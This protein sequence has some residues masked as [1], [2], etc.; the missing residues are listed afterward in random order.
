MHTTP[1]FPRLLATAVL[2][3]LTL[4]TAHA[5]D[6]QTRP[7]SGSFELIESNGG[8]DVYLSQGPTAAIVAEAAAGALPHLLTEVRNGTLVVQWEKGF[9]PWKLAQRH[10]QARVYITMPRLSGLTLSGGADGHGQTSFTADDFRIQ[11]SGGSD[12]TL[13]LQ[14]KNL[15]ADAS[16]GSDL[17]LSGRAERQEIG[18]SGGSDYH[19][20]GLQSTTAR[21]SASGGSDADAWVEGELEASA[22]GGSDLRY[23]GAGRAT[24]AHAGGASSVRHVN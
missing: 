5:Q 14:V 6:K 8:I 3:G 1:R 12:V 23:K 9:Q 7:V 21:I 24:S 10:S 16:G 18:I 2:A 13:A 19:G 4:G 15:R 22:S 17:S 20:F 11:A